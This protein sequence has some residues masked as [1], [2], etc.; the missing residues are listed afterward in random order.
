MRRNFV[1]A[2]IKN[3]RTRGEE[4]RE[5]SLP[6]VEMESGSSISEAFLV[7]IPQL[8][9]SETFSMLL[10]LRLCELFNRH[11]RQGASYTKMRAI[12]FCFLLKVF[13]GGAI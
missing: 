3:E 2:N 10:L 6:C 13:Q 11:S 1:K 8:H 4:R 12:P 5:K 9:H 7:F